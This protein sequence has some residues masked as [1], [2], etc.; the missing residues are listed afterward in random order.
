LLSLNMTLPTKAVSQLPLSCRSHPFRYA[1]KNDRLPPSP[2]SLGLSIAMIW[3]SVKRDFFIQNF[4][5]IEKILPL[6]PPDF[7]GITP[8]KT[9]PQR[10]ANNL[11]YEDMPW[12]PCPSAGGRTRSTLPRLTIACR[13]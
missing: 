13:S 4:L 6:T 8:F 10:L 3:L 1:Q 5:H 11:A 12:S 2:P 9:T 7:R